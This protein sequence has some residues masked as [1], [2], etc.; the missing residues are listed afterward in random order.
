MSYFFIWIFVPCSILLPLIIGLT[1]LRRFKKYDLVIFIYVTINGLVNLLVSIL[2]QNHFNNLPVFHIF[3]VIE[4]I[5][6][7]LFFNAVYNNKTYSV[8]SNCMMVV[9]TL[10]SILNTLFLQDLHKFNTYSRSLGAII[11][12]CYC[13]YYF[14]YLIKQSMPLTNSVT[15]YTSGIFIYFSTS[16]IIF[17]MSNITLT[18]D[19]ELNK[20]IWHVHA[21]MVLVMYIFITRGFYIGKSRG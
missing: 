12:M 19:K 1:N 11:L 15:W 13:I 14:Y 9:F 18:I 8:F 4:F 10:L 16:F 5:L 17:I 20:V 7:S 6:L 2:A 21:A 3:T